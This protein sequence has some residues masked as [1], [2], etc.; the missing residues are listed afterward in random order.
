MKLKHNEFSTAIPDAWDDRTMV[1]LVASFGAGEFATN[2][3]ITRHFVEA[4]ESLEDFAQE[5]QKMMRE[6]IANFELLD[7]RANELNGRPSCQQLHRF[8]TQNGVLQQVQTFILANR[9]V[10]VITG[11]STV[12]DFER[13]IQAFREIVEN[14]AIEELEQTS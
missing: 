5:Q 4:H 2:I 8:P 12:N 3:V 11:T 14:F 6:S 13:H 7:Y 1:T 10:Y 9:R